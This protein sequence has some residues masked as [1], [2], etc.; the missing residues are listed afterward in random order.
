MKEMK[1]CRFSPDIKIINVDQ[2]VVQPPPIHY[3]DYHVYRA[4]RA[5]RTYREIDDQKR[6]YGEYHKQACKPPQLRT[7]QREA[8]RQMLKSSKSVG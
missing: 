5:P 4:E 8:E 1:D 3:A 7:G 6:S 2:T